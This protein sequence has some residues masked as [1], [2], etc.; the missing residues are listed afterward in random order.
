MK[1]I[2]FP[3]WR[4][5]PSAVANVNAAR[6]HVQLAGWVALRIAILPN[7]GKEWA[8]KNYT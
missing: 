8:S 1:I 7:V 5:K 6:I 2:L 4:H 3:S